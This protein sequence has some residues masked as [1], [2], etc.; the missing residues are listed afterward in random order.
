MQSE[1]RAWI[2]DER[3]RSRLNGSDCEFCRDN[4]G[5]GSTHGSVVRDLRVAR[6][7]LARNQYIRGYS[8]LILKYHA[9]EFCALDRGVRQDLSEDIADA[10]RA[11]MGVLRPIKLNLEMQG[12]VV[13]HLHC[14][15]KPR[16]E[17]DRP[18]HARIFQ[19]AEFVELTEAQRE[20]LCD[21][22]RASL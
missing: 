19:D 3:W 21:R 7:V 22:L 13:P 12:N 14:H 15:I 2:L 4:E 20:E 8:V 18:G 10:S 9:I 16:F 6:W 5:V 1:P 11:L 17:T